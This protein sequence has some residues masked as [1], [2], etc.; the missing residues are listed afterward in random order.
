[1]SFRFYLG[2]FLLLSFGCKKV[3]ADPDAQWNTFVSRYAES[4]CDLREDCDPTQFT[5]EFGGDEEVCKRAVVTNEN[6]GKSKKVEDGCEFDAD[7]GSLCLDSAQQIGCQDWV[8]GQ[9]EEVCD[10]VWTCD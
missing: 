5:D 10:M 2:S 7:Q 1:M 4:Y 8:D 3:E 9:L 6:K